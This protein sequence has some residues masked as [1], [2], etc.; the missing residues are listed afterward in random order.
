MSIMHRPVVAV[1]VAVLA[2][3]FVSCVG[4]RPSP[5]QGGP[6]MFQPRGPVTAIADAE[7]FGQHPLAAFQRTGNPPLPITSL[8]ANIPL[9]LTGRSGAFYRM[10]LRD[11]SVA[12]IATRDVT[13]PVPRIPEVAP[14]AQP[15]SA[16][17][18]EHGQQPSPADPGAGGGDFID[19]DRL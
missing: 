2:C 18:P 15:A 14:G 9:E 11:G 16:L 6:T 1:F 5:E 4:T 8:P 12:W 10:Q 7:V 13:G 17:S 19:L 3:A